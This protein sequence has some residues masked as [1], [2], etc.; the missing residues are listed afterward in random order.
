MHTHFFLSVSVTVTRMGTPRV[1]Q[2]HRK[3]LDNFM[4]TWFKTFWWFSWLIVSQN[5]FL[6]NCRWTFCLLR[7]FTP[8]HIFLLLLPPMCRGLWHH[9]LVVIPVANFSKDIF[10]LLNN[11]IQNNDIKISIVEVLYVRTYCSFCTK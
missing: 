5:S 1:S 11:T 2:S 7:G 4:L 10:L 9:M 8:L 3:A 6:E